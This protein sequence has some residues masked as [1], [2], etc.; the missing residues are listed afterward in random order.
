[1]ECNGKESCADLDPD[2]ICS[3]SDTSLELSRWYHQ[4]C[5]VLQ[6]TNS[7]ELGWKQR[8]FRSNQKM[9]ICENYTQGLSKE[10]VGNIWCKYEWRMYMFFAIQMWEYQCRICDSS[11]MEAK[12]WHEWA[13]ILN[14][15]VS[16]ST[17]CFDPLLWKTIIR[18]KVH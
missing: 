12:H 10:E 8:H 6:K 11:L 1:M 2:L 5:Q 9:I 7:Y 17:L 16:Y 3:G 4:S 15:N 14:H 18:Q 13:W